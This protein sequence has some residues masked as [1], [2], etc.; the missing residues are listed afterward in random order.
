MTTTTT[1]TFHSIFKAQY[2]RQ[3]IF[4][5]IS[6]ISKQL[7]TDSRSS[8]IR[9]DY[10]RQPIEQRS[11]KGRDII[12]LPLLGMISIFAMPWNYIRHYLPI[13]C[14]Q[15]VAKRRKRVITLYSLHPNATL[16]TLEHLLEW[17]PENFLD[18]IYLEKYFKDF[19]D[20]EILAFIVK[21]SYPL[22]RKNNKDRRSSSSDQEKNAFL[23]WAMGIACN[24]GYLSSVKLIHPLIKGGRMTCP[25]GWS[26]HGYTPIEIAAMAGFIDVVKTEGCETI[27]MDWAADLG[28]LE[29]V[30]FL[31]EHRTEGCT[32][33]AMDN[34]CRR[35]YFETVKFL[36]ERR[37]EG[38]SKEA[39]DWAA[40]KGHFE[41]VKFLHEH[42]SEGCTNKAM[43]KAAEK[44]HI[45]IVK[46]LDEHRSEGA[47]TKA[48][49][50]AAEKG[51]IEIIKY[52]HEHR[53]EGA[54]TDA[55]VYASSID[56]VKFLHFNRT[57][58]ATRDT[59]NRAASYGRLD[60]VKFLQEHR[61]E[62]CSLSIVDY[63]VRRGNFEMVSYIFDTVMPTHP[64]PIRISTLSDA[65][66]G[67]KLDVFYYLYDRFS[68][69]SDIWTPDIMDKAAE[70]GHIEIVK[71]L[72]EHRSEGATTYAMDLAARNGHIEIVKFLHEHR[73]E[74]ATTNAM[75]W[76]AEKGH[77]EVVKYLH[78]HRS[79]GATTNAMDKAARGGHIEIVKLVLWQFNGEEGGTGSIES[80][81]KLIKD[82]KYSKNQLYTDNFEARH[83]LKIHLKQLL[84]K[85]KDNQHVDPSQKLTTK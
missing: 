66:E 61:S 22:K 60:I 14:T 32:K 27:A 16:D 42:R 79:E 2:I 29:M 75:D 21:N 53:S 56:I 3:S 24:K 55:M 64:F 38:A 82:V 12:K 67:G 65:L 31:H 19:S 4:N 33:N 62:G 1:T 70:K 7:Y 43:D 48:M 85:D 54:T 44:G 25:G 59:M 35:G 58:G 72:H 18:S 84:L 45:E 78:E 77:F 13:D 15:I 68:D 57:E 11:L 26:I 81:A 30:K 41:I 20:K 83:L 10:S 69:K 47:T 34:A 36:H 40:E 39:M 76:A 23:A 37:T 50:L 74:G 71:L 73:S 28:H 52:L 6:D 51:H 63:P 17:S 5:H 80:L 9:D 49:D 8:R 46:Y